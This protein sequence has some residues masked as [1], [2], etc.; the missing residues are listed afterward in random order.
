MHKSDRG[1]RITNCLQRSGQGYLIHLFIQHLLSTWVLC[2]INQLGRNKTQFLLSRKASEAL[3]VASKS[4][5]SYSLCVQWL[6]VV[7]H[8]FPCKCS[9]ILGI[10]DFFSH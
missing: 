2:S 6:P 5:E 7:A 1:P 9:I 10:Y 3:D 4:F 8:M